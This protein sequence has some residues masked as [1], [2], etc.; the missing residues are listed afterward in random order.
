MKKGR[1][2]IALILGVILGIVISFAIYYL[3]V[4]DI[5]WGAFLKDELIPTAFIVLTSIGAISVLAM[6][7]INRVIHTI[8][9]FNQVT[10]DVNST[11]EHSENTNNE[12][13]AYEKELNQ[14]IRVI[15]EIVEP[16]PGEITDIKKMC[17]LGFCNSDELVEKGCAA[18]I[19]KVGKEN[20][21]IEEVGS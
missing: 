18:E 10:N 3:T 20:E 8:E 19:A 5:A 17:K 12:I 1:L 2:I 6:P 15:K 16:L 13:K 7:I 9:K 4:G 14:F 21:Q 11:A